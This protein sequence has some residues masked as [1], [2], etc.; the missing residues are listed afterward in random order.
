MK[1]V[2]PRWQKLKKQKTI[3]AK[4]RFKAIGSSHSAFLPKT[5]FLQRKG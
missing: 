4:H 2:G 1:T 3:C 5:A